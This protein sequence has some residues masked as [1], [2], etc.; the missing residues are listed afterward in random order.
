MLRGYSRIVVSFFELIRKDA[1]FC[2]N[3]ECHNAFNVLKDALVK[4]PILIR[5]DFTKPF[6]LDVDWSTKGVGAILSQWIGR[7]E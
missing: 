4:A 6:I 7:N 5:L 2:W 1:T 3:D